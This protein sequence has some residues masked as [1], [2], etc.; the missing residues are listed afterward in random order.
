VIFEEEFAILLLPTLQGKS[1]LHKEQAQK[2]WLPL[3]I[4]PRMTIGT[5]WLLYRFT[6]SWRFRRGTLCFSFEILS[7]IKCLYSKFN[8]CR[9]HAAKPLWVQQLSPSL[10]IIGTRVIKYMKKKKYIVLQEDALAINKRE[11][12]L[13]M[14]QFAV[15][16]STDIDSSCQ[17]LKSLRNFIST[18]YREGY[19][20]YSHS[21][22]Y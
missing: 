11:S 13:Q 9:K 1:K 21:L 4:L 2:K 10:G 14:M 5:E 8:L 18:E 15:L 3:P 17:G 19:L 6:I 7:N 12:D 20:L 16:D 22:K